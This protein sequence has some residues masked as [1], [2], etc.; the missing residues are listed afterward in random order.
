MGIQNNVVVCQA[1]SHI[2]C[3]STFF[4]AFSICFVFCIAEVNS[5]STHPFYLFDPLYKFGSLVQQKVLPSIGTCCCLSLSLSLYPWLC[6]DV[7]EFEHPLM[8]IFT[9]LFMRHMSTESWHRSR[10]QC[11]IQHKSQVVQKLVR[12]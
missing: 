2:T 9:S 10:Y 5:Y 8:C 3:C 4:P 11:T 7:L 6:V 12:K 1:G